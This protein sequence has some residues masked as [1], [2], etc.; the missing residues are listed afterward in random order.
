LG[1]GFITCGSCPTGYVGN[2]FN[3]TNYDA[4]SPNPC[5]SGVACTDLAPPSTG[6]TCGSCP[7]GYAGNGSVCTNYDACS[8]NPC[9]VGVAC[10]DLA[11]PSTGYTCGSCPF[12]YV[13]NG[14]ACTY[15][16]A[17]SG[18]ICTNISMTN[19]P[20]AISPSRS[21]GAVASA[22]LGTAVALLGDV[23]GDGIADFAFG[24][25]GFSSGGV[26]R[27]GTVY[28]VFGTGA[29]INAGTFPVATLNG[30]NGF[31]VVDEF[32]TANQ[33]VG[34]AAAGGDVNGD[35]ISDIV[36]GASALTVRY[37]K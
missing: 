30:T 12:S 24:A 9:F 21:E 28:V 31:R 37:T 29:P 2:G 26:N 5:F 13:G 4:C 14:S 36:I 27:L 10:T 19:P 20:A 11:P 7:A 18:A 17:C 22:N 23:N 8:P 35:G 6:Y 34:N 3:C 32:N 16:N 33:A 25:T 15:I 1:A